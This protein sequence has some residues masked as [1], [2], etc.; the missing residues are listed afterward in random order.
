MLYLLLAREQKE[1]LVS[2]E[3]LKEL[4]LSQGLSQAQLSDGICSWETLSR[5]ERGR[6]KPNR[7]NL[8]QMFQ[9]MGLERERYYGYI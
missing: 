6:S 8:Y 1:L 3:L 7:K 2:K 5:I 9:K 4:R